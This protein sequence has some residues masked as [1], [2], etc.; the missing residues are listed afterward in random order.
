[1]SIYKEVTAIEVNITR[2]STVG[3]LADMLDELDN[4]ICPSITLFADLSGCISIESKEFNL[5][6]GKGRV[7]L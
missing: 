1:M 4:G 5:S 7:N 3:E 2:E 6:N